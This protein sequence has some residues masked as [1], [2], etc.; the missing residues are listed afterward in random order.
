MDRESQAKYTGSVSEMQAW[1]LDMRRTS[2]LPIRTNMTKSSSPAALNPINAIREWWRSPRR[3]GLF[4]LGAAAII[5]YEAARAWYRP[6]IYANG[7]EDFHLA[8]TLG[9]SL[10]TIATVLVF[11]SLFGRSHADGLFVLR[12]SAIAVAVYELAHPLLGKPIDPYDLAATVVAGVICQAA[13]RW[14]YRRQL[15]PAAIG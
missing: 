10:G 3:L 6:Y 14:H 15:G 2:Q 12:A 13:Y 8:D 7:I 11:A 1:L 4:G 9:N 5:L